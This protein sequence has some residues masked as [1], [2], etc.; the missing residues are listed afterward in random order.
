VADPEVIRVLVVDDHQLLTDALVQALEEGP[1]VEVVGVGATVEDGMRMA[2]SRRPDV[3]LMDYQLPD[4]D[5]VAATRAILE[6]HPTI[7]VV[8][9]TSFKNDDVLLGAM[10]AGC[11]GFLT[12]DQGVADVLSAV[13]AAAAGEA[14]IS[15]A[16]LS[17]LLPRLRRQPTGRGQDLSPREREVLGLLVEGL[18]NDAIAERLV[19]SVNTVRNHV[20]AVI[21]KLDAH[22]KLEAVAVATREG[23][24]HLR[25][26]WCSCTT[27]VGLPASGS[28][29]VTRRR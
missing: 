17:R 22:S 12:K 26:C 1:D 29:R 24:V 2:D 28:R 8:M 18:S 15:P 20:Q 16:M 13:R 10:E 25:R 3:V 4:G 19:L 14:L 21:T 27:A 6:R 7:Q 9:V 11:C 23:L 5:G